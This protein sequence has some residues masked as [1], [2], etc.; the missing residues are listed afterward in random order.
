MAAKAEPGKSGQG[1][2]LGARLSQIK[3]FIA[4]VRRSLDYYLTQTSQVRS[5]RRILLTGSGSQLRNFGP[6]LEK[7]LQAQQVALGDP[8]ART[9]ASSGVLAAVEADRFGCVTAVGLALGGLQ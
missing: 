7:G 6:Y 5:I 4:E 1:E 3:Q 8:L 9:Q 2:G